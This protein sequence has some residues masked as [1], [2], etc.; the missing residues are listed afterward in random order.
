MEYSLMS[1]SLFYGLLIITQEDFK[2]AVT[3]LHQLFSL[4]ADH[5]M[6]SLQQVGQKILSFAV[7]GISFV[8]P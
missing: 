2:S 1:V 4:L 8:A 6:S 5:L 3:N 7:C